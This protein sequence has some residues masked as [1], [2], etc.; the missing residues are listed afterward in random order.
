LGRRCRGGVRG[1]AK[2]C[3]EKKSGIGGMSDAVPFMKREIRGRTRAA[4]LKKRL[5]R[6]GRRKRESFSVRGFMA[7]V[8]GPEKN[9]DAK[10]SGNKGTSAAVP[11]T[12][13]AII[14]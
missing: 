7:G 5:S 2:N 4:S 10:M 3:D 1:F 13:P 6:F 12:T 9:C 11:F 14:R 8:R